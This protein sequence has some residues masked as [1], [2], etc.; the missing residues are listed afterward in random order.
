MNVEKAELNKILKNAEI[1]ALIG[2]IGAGVEGT[3]DNMHFDLSNLRY[4]KIVIMTDAD[5]DGGHITT[6]LLTFFYRYMRP[7]VEQGHLYIAQPPLYR[8]MIGREK[9]GEYLYDDAALQVKIVQAN[10]DG[11]KYEIQR[12]KGLGE[13]NADQLWETTMDPEK[14]VLKHVGIEDQI[15]RASCRE[16]VLVAV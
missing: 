16:R 5:M 14:R 10:R 15:G 6:L 4:H 12:F 2:A 7:I 3:G 11:K 9:K 8:I 13:M 1:R